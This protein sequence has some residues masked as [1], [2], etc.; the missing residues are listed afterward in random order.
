MGDLSDSATVA[1]APP[2]AP[3]IQ[4]SAGLDITKTAGASCYS[5]PNEIIVYTYNVHNVGFTAISGPFAV[6]DN[7]I[8]QWDCDDQGAEG[9]ELGVDEWLTCHGYY[10]VR[11][12]D[13]GSPIVNV[14]HVEG[15]YNNEVVY[16]NQASAG[17]EFCG[18]TT[19]QHK[20][21]EKP[22]VIIIPLE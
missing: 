3:P 18:Q 15:F 4:T 16:S 17:V 19:K 7:K 6:I 13:L 5:K 21:G 12:T 11:E 9:F 20:P 2:L 10:K 1:F 22:P 14:A 8:D